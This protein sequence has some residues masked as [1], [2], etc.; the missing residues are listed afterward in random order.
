[1]ESGLLVSVTLGVV[2]SAQ[3]SE[4][5]SGL[6]AM[7]LVQLEDHLSEGL[8]IAGDSQVD[9]GVLRVTVVVGES[10]ACVGEE[11]YGVVQISY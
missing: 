7:I 5:L 4:V 3:R 2:P 1:M 10:A 9:L 8:S 6:G 11:L